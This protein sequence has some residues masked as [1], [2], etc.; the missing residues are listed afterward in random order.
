MDLSDVNAGDW[1]FDGAGIIFK[2]VR[3]V[4]NTPGAKKF[5]IKPGQTVDLTSGCIKRKYTIRAEAES[6]REDYLS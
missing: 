6:D 5:T 4:D 1:F 3:E 2:I